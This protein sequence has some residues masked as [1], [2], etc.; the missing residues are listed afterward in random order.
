VNR[1][2]RKTLVREYKEA[3]LPTGI[4]RIRNTTSGRSLVGSS[5]NLPGMLNRQRFQLENGS[6]RDADLQADWNALGSNAFEFAVLDLLEPRDEP[7]YDPTAELEVLMAL[8]LEKLAA[9]GE[10]L[11]GRPAHGG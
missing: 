8:W 6:H 11:Y 7:S 1:I 2:D 3:A 9:S 10:S 5:V 4:Y